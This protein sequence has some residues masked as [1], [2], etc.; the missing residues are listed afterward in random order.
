MDASGLRM[1]APRQDDLPLANMYE[2]ACSRVRG[3]SKVCSVV[4]SAP[5]SS[6]QQPAAAVMEL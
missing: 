1:R 3:Q 5:C 4:R 2:E 6:L